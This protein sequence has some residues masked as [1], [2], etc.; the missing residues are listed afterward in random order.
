MNPLD[1]QS[2]PARPPIWRRRYLWGVP[3]IAIVDAAFTQVYF[4]YDPRLAALTSLLGKLPY[5]PMI[6]ATP[7]IDPI[8]AWSSRLIG[9]D[10]ARFIIFFGNGLFWGLFII[11]L[12]HAI[13][14]RRHINKS[15]T[16]QN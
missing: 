4:H 1:Y 2:P 9:S 16:P 12:W 5:F 13:G 7:E 8:W 3:L 15:S 10:V 6:L 11:G 14:W